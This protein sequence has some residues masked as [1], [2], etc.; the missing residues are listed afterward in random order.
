MKSIQINLLALLTV[1]ITGIT[2][3]D[4][5]PDS[6]H[7]I[8]DSVIEQP[9]NHIQ[10]FS[11]LEADIAQQ[12]KRFSDIVD[13]AEKHIR[14]ASK[15][16]QKTPYS[17]VYIHGFSA[18]RQELSPT[19]EQVADRIGANAFYTRLRGHGRT[20]DAMAEPS[21]EDWKKDTLEALNIGAQIGEQ[22]ILISASTGS[23]L[24]T[25]LLSQ[26]ESKKVAA[27]IMVS[28][29]YGVKSSTAKILT[30]PMG[31][32]VARWFNGDY[33]SFTPVSEK[34][35]KYWTERYPLE[36]VVPM[37]DLVDEVEEMDKS[38]FTQPQFLIFSPTDQVIDV[39]KIKS[40]AEEFVNA[41]VTMY[42]FLVSKDHVQHVLS[43]DAC[44]PSST[45]AMTDL[46]VR[47]IN[48]NFKLDRLRPLH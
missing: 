8:S 14:W 13:G 7:A 34:H 21:N 23:T 1:F 45:Q 11:Q 48:N 4:T 44:S 20:D 16:K 29:N 6:P 22:V 19:T 10:L 17:I 26:P 2:S 36:A 43:G 42:P 40:T 28:A 32:T 46:M 5:L 47:Y 9:S 31:L 30:W 25:W 15:D 37:L 3:A 33:V 24:T 39:D 41:P 38:Q 12:E 27:N 35:A 18:T